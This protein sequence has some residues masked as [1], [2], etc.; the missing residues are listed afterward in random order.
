MSRPL[1]HRW[2]I[3]HNY[4][5]GITF[6]KWCKLLAQN[7]FRIS[8]A[9]LHRAA[10]IT[11][12]SL[13][14]SAFACIENIRFGRKIAQTKITRPPLFVLGHWR[15]GTTLLQELLAQD[16]HLFQTP[17]TYQVVNPYTFLTTEN[18][19][20][21]MFPWLVPETRPMDNMA[22]KFTSP[23]EDEFAPLLMSLSSVYL[24]TSF[25]G[26][27]AHYDRHLSFR[28]ADPTETETWKAAFIQFCKKIS[29]SDQRS[30]L[31]K[32]PPHTARIRLNP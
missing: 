21:R 22:L 5:T 28:D 11:L 14:N 15:S 23:Q 32:S 12:A 27:M 20:T 10:V 30:L 8:P 3:S 29:M 18:F 2:S 13:S 6:G 24:G 26:R 31:L 7:G 4:M 16:T 17:N 1:K 19:T 25:P 9:Y